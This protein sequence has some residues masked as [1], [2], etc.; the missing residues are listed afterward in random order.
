MSLSITRPGADLAAATVDGVRSGFLGAIGST[1][2]EILTS[3]VGASRYALSIE[4]VTPLEG[5]RVDVTWTR[6]RTDI[7][8][9]GAIANIRTTVTVAG[10]EIDAESANWTS[11]AV[12]NT[13]TGP[14]QPGDRVVVEATTDDFGGATFRVT[15]TVPD[16]PTQDGDGTT[17]PTE[18]TEPPSTTPDEPV[19][20]PVA[21]SVQGPF[22]I[23]EILVA[24]GVLLGGLAF[25]G[26]LA[27]LF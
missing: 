13:S 10:Q 7:D 2:T 24:A 12:T 3:G 20:P 27:I 19:V 1:T 22:P 14:G 15:A 6:E 8:G 18:P 17:E 5:G 25:L 9:S 16:F 21:P 11:F 26:L 4:S 23:F